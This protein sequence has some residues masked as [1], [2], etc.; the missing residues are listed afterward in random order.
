MSTIRQDIIDEIDTLL[1]AISIANGYSFDV[2]GKVF[3]W[4]DIPI[5]EDDYPCI[6]FRDV[7]DYFS[8]D[9]ESEHVLEIEIAVIPTPGSTSTAA[10]RDMLQDVLTAF[11]ALEESSNVD[12][13]GSQYMGS[14][15]E[16]EHL[17]KIYAGASMLFNVEYV[18]DRWEI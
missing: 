14:E 17:K 7:R 10:L 4:R 1:N 15:M 16:V 8:E 13:S 5:S 3:E 6:I 9:S 18:T 2:D 11:S 12:V